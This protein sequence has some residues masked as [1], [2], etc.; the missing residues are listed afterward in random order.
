MRFRLLNGILDRIFS[1]NKRIAS[2]NVGAEKNVRVDE[3][4]SGNLDPGGYGS[5]WVR[6]SAS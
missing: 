6:R 3:Q 5:D 1:A 4:S 2:L